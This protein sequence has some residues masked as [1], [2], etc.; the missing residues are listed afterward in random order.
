MPILKAG[1]DAPGWSSPS[2]LFLILVNLIPL[3]GVLAL[4]WDVGLIMLL[5]WMETVVIGLY[6]VPKILT[7]RQSAVSE[8]RGRAAAKAV[9]FGG[10]LFLAVFFMVHFGGFNAGHYLFLDGMFGLPPVD[11]Q[12][13]IAAGGIALSHGFSFLHNWIGKREFERSSPSL[14][15]FMPYGRIVVMHI[16]IIAGGFLVMLFED[17]LV[18]LLLLIGMKTGVDLI[19][20]R[21]GHSVGRSVAAGTGR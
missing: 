10:R 21:A 3:V 7:S 9:G 4:G 17:G 14:Q 16:V 5:Y 13:L 15:M 1:E 20:H 11:V 8:E 6:N 18:F 19:S 2:V 12:A